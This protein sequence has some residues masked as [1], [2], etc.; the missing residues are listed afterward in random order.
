M[1]YIV[2]SCE[3]L[4]CESWVF[5]TR[6]ECLFYIVHEL[7]NIIQTESEFHVGLNELYVDCYLFL[8]KWCILSFL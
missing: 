3:H 4:K 1:I 6:H 8:F 2:S 5:N 7:I